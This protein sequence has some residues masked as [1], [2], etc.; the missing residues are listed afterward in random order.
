MELASIPGWLILIIGLPI[1][2]ISVIIAI[3]L[4]FMSR[5]RQRRQIADE[6]ERQEQ[7]TNDIALASLITGIIS[8]LSVPA[9]F[10]AIPQIFSIL[11]IVFGARSLKRVVRPGINSHGRAVTGLALGIIGLILSIAFVIFVS[12]AMREYY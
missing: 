7:S 11:A 1:A 2:F 6:H 10:Y 4:Y 5:S 12:I 8:I 3:S 9:A